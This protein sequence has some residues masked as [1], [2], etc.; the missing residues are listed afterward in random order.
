VSE[1][2]EALRRIGAA[3]PGGVQVVPAS[4]LDRHNLRT[5]WALCV[6][7]DA[8]I[9][10]EL[11]AARYPAQHRVD[12][13]RVDGVRES[14]LGEARGGSAELVVLAPLRRDDDLRDYAALPRIAERLRLPG[15]CPWDREQTH[16]SLRPHLLE[17]AYE[18]LDAID[19]GDLDRLASELGDLLFQ[20]VIHAQL[21]HEEGTFDMSEVTRRI[22]DKL[23]RR[24]P[25]VFQ[26][27][28]IEGNDLL[29]QW[30]RIKRAESEEPASVISGVP[31]SL[32]ALFMAERL[33]ER[34]ERVKVRPP[35][36]DGDGVGERLFALASEARRSGVDA[37]QAL[38]AVN[39]R[40]AE[41]FERLE[42]LARRGGRELE[43]LTERELIDLWKQAR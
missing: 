32:P 37:E 11:L 42:A 27:T 2:A 40:F 24:H 33:L 38:R 21:A 30:E 25:H 5:E 14:T 10:W 8:A 31:R 36:D 3:Y 22:S 34:A 41:R 9:P 16:Q 29:L 23:V 17:E 1:A 39:R 28:A 20:V 43:T 35:I 18:A 15:G 13:I 19:D 12:L 26:G 4:G 7:A 6:V